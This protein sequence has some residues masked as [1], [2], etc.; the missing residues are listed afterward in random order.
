[1][2]AARG[3]SSVVGMTILLSDRRAATA[4][5]TVDLRAVA[6]N[7]EA[8]AARLPGALMAV[9]KADG[10]GHGAESVARV[11]L[12]HGASWL[13]V[14]S[15]EEARALRGAGLRAPILSW[16][17]AVEAD[18]TA[19]IGDDVDLAVPSLAHLESITR[20]GIG[21]RLHLHLDTGLARD[22][23]APGEW[24]ALC[25]A[26]RAAELAG[27]ARVVG[28]MGH[29]PC[30]D[31]PHDTANAAGRA[32]FDWGVGV[33]RA[34]GLRPPLRHLAATAAALTDPA[35]HHTMARVGAGLVGIDP[36]GTSAV[37]AGLRGAMS[38]TAPVVGVRHV[39]S[40][41]SVGY[42]HTWAAD[43]PTTLA[44]LPLGYADGLPRATSGRAQVL[45]RGRRRLVV[46]RVSMDQVVVE[47]GDD[48][49]EPGEVATIFGPGTDGE[50]TV[51]DWAVVGRHDRARDR[52]R[53][54]CARDTGARVRAGRPR[55]AVIGGG[56]N[57]EHEVSLASAASV[58]DGLWQAGYEVV[59]LTIDPQGTWLDRGGRPVGLTGAA[60]L[61]RRCDATLPGR[62][63]PA[64][65]GRH[66]GRARRPGGHPVDR[67]RRSCR[68]ARHGQVGHQA[69]RRGGR[70]RH[71]SG[72]APDVPHLPLDP[73]RGGQAGRGRVEPRGRRSSPTPPSSTRHWRAV[74]PR[75]PRARRGRR[76]RARDRPRR[77]R[78]PGRL[79]LLGA[80]PG[81]ARRRRLR[82]H[83]QVL[84]RR[85]AS[86]CPHRS[87][88]WS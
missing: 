82:P 65:G 28:V 80:G 6:A 78:S 61:I 59:R 53:Y 15:L 8:I 84:P 7:T 60:C 21:A 58:A 79:A 41:T 73:P 35:S 25:R 39:P 24:R 2:S 29:L 5:L 22:G 48:Q 64:W 37:G 86:S 19:A 13:G 30:A 76:P 77:A 34:A 27:S 44:L 4:S 9:V 83:R 63:R 14:T 45:L 49:V 54:R 72:R 52:D 32:V 10:F 87:T 36:T 23:A 42:G 16:L 51:G 68:G 38:L 85:R 67:L 69:G 18:F 1:M 57:C 11:A 55:V 26:A 43:R 88:R 71:R 17:N 3:T 31:D 47:L 81:G 46:G 74:R 20:A 12:A 62:A 40:G 56:A 75:R 50:P 33:A 66:P 70:R